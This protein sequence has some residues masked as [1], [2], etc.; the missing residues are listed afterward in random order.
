MIRL[1][2]AC[3]AFAALAAA[4]NVVDLTPD[5]FDDI[6]NGDRAVFVEFYAP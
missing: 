1:L 2:V 4:S 5:T 3:V 6:V